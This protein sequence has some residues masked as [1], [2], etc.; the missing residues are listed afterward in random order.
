MATNHHHKTHLL[1]RR[2]AGMTLVEVMM[3]FAVFAIAIVGGLGGIMFSLNS[4]DSSRTA[5]QVGQILVNE[6][7]AI[8]LRKF[9][10]TKDLGGSLPKLPGIKQLA[11]AVA[12]P[13]EGIPT[14]VTWASVPD[15]VKEAVKNYQTGGTIPGSPGS[16]INLYRTTFLPFAV[17]GVTP[18]NGKNTAQVNQSNIVPTA[19][20]QLL[21]PKNSTNP[22]N[23]TCER[24]IGTF[25]PGVPYTAGDGAVVVLVVS[26]TN[27]RGDHTRV[28]SSTFV[29]NGF[30][31]QN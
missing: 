1:K 25:N 12:A 10:G 6:M 24:Y 8:R 7:E 30:L 18:T 3:G 14:L 23:Y 5:A 15:K 21:N 26:W 31:S 13:P 22:D 29:S 27:R 4:I 16:A 17:Y 9:D 28:F 11:A 2:G 19:T 20:L